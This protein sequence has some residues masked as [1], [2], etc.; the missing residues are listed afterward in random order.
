MYVGGLPPLANEQVRKI[1]SLER[2]DS[3]NF[4]DHVI[5]V[6]LRLLFVTNVIYIYMPIII[7]YLLLR[8]LFAVTVGF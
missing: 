3:L 6:A 5:T 2:I 1:S 7:K 8:P 4:I